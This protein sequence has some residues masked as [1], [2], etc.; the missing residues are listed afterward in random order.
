MAVFVV[1]II[2]SNVLLSA[3][4]YV[5]KVMLNSNFYQLTYYLFNGKAGSGSFK[6][7]MDT[8]ITCIPFALLSI[9]VTV[10][11]IILVK[12]FKW[13]AVKKFIKIYAI[14]LLCFCVLLKI[15]KPEV[16]MIIASTTWLRVFLS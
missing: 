8:I 2:I 14:S 1:L 12:H 7:V 16:S 15:P 9:I 10:L 3:V 5:N 13:F 6:V 4:Y 11:P